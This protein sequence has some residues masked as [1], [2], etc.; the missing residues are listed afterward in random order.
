LTERADCVLISVQIEA[1]GLKGLTLSEKLTARS[2]G[3]RVSVRQFGLKETYKYNRVTLEL[4]DGE[5][6][7]LQVP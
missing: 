6:L 5:G 2:C 1:A 4:K 7:W 3:V